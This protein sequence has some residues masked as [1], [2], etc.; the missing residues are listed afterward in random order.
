MPAGIRAGEDVAQL[1]KFTRDLRVRPR[2]ID[3]LLAPVKDQ[4]AIGRI[5][6]LPPQFIHHAVTH[7]KHFGLKALLDQAVLHARDFQID[8]GIVRRRPRA[9]FI[10]Q[11]QDAHRLI[12]TRHSV[13]LSDL[14][15]IVTN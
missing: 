10:A 11:D 3:V 15:C 14:L 12:P 7:R 13:S 5:A 8:F 1:L 6:G 9:V 2:P 4:P